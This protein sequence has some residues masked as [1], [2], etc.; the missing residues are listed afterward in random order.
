M[1]SEIVLLFSFSRS[2]PPDGHQA[3]RVAAERDGLRRE[4]QAAR[5]AHASETAQLRGD[6]AALSICSLS[7]LNT[8]YKK[9]EAGCAA[10]REALIRRCAAAQ[11]SGGGA[12]SGSPGVATCTVCLDEDNARDTRLNCGHVFCR[13]C[14]ARLGEC[15]TCRTRV[16]QRDRVFL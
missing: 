5:A 4:L 1:R 8:L 6:A 9:S 13:G 11:A 7:E 3:S 2:E 14:A 10:V 15:P 16:S 12:S